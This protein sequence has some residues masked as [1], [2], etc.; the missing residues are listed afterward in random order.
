MC[1]QFG[2]LTTSAEHSADDFI[3]DAFVTSMLRGVDSSGVVNID[4]ARNIY[5]LHKLPVAGLHFVTDKV[6]KRLVRYAGLA[7][8]LT[9]CHVRAATQG[10]VR[11]SNAHPFEIDTGEGIL[12]GTHNGT[13]TGWKY[14]KY[15]K[16]YDVDSE[17]ALSLI[18]EKGIEAFK[19]FTGAY[20]FVW[21]DGRDGSK[22]HMVRNKERP[23][24]VAFLKGGGMA[25]AS[26]PGMLFW[27]L[28]RNSIQM[29]GR[30]VELLA[31]KHYEFSTLKARDVTI[32]E[33]PK[34][35][36]PL[37]H[38]TGTYGTNISTTYRTTVEKMDALIAAAAK[39]KIPSEEKLA[40]DYGWY[41]EKAEF[42]P[43]SVN[44]KNEV[45]GIAVVCNTEFDAIVR[46]DTSGFA[47][48]TEWVSTVVGVL[49]E[50]QD[51]TLVLSRPSHT[52]ALSL[53]HVPGWG[54]DD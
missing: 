52:V 6:T 2:I 40:R 36:Q 24:S 41:G 45:E 9:M 46:G 43:I 27:L 10:E 5:E 23:M 20:S 3:S 50:G 14:S 29:D 53:D 28:E 1:G 17:W 26:E 33:L 44:S 21:W 48:N 32:T 39:I 11:L 4:L 54:D 13:L 15:G 16:D 38:S 51:M 18:A 8:Q 7:K 34:K 31:D 35:P 12:I 19:E 47:F 42:V 37:T 30:I 22:L 49:E 25:W